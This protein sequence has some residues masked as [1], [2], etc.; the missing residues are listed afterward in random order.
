MQRS[1]R[2]NRKKMILYKNKNK[3]IQMNK[4]KS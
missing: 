2:L 3:K 4:I 1:K